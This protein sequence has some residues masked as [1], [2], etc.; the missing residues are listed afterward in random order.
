MD[1]VINANK[2]NPPAG[3]APLT[4]HSDFWL[5]ALTQLGQDPVHT[6]LADLFRIHHKLDDGE[7]LIISPIHWQVTHNDAMITAYGDE[8]NLD[9]AVARIWFAEI[10]QFLAQDGFKL[11]YHSPYYWLLNAAN[12]APLTSPNLPLLKHQSLMPILAELDNT[13]Y[14]QRL[15]TEL[16]MFLASHPLNAARDRI[17]PINGVWF[18]GGGKLLATAEQALRP[19]VTDDPIMQHA[20]TQCLP[21][22]FENLTL[23]DDTLFAI[24]YP[25]VELLRCD[26]N[27]QR[28][29]EQLEK[30]TQKRKVNWY[31]NNMAYQVKRKPWYKWSKLVVHTH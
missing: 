14:W 28:T 3:T 15:F 18:W 5:N 13:M 1:V 30:I 2:D 16:Q 23:N 27:C 21:V 26:T 7:W 6:P 10:S 24:C 31:W 25:E 12:K 8:L 20:F 11:I 4:T 29:L 19:I 17:I 9:D 22:N